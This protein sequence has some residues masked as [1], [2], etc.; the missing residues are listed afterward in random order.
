MKIVYPGVP[1]AK[2]RARV[3]RWGSYTPKASKDYE[4]KMILFLT[5]HLPKEYKDNVRPIGLSVLFHMPVPKM[6][7]GRHIKK[8]E[9]EFLIGKVHIIKP[10]Y[11]NLLKMVK[12]AMNRAGY[13]KD[14]C[15]VG[16][17]FPPCGKVYSKEPRTEIIYESLGSTYDILNTPYRPDSH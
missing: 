10:D 9:R 12:D 3:T 5:R 1:K 17:M 13:F 7:Q 4:D 16:V 8:A 2:A 14:D 11:D 15:Q 6:I